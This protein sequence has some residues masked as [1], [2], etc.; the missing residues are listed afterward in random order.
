MEGGASSAISSIT[1]ALST[2]GTSFSSD[3]TSVVT[4]MLPIALGILGLFMAIKLG[5]KFFRNT[6][7][8]AG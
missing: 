1:T 2:W 6:A 3:A 7:N 5:I 8:K 4:T